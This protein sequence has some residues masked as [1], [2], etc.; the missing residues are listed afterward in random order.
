MSNSILS[1]PHF[2]NEEAA[3]RFVE[4]AVWARGPV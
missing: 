4:K 2:H 1:A 3:Y